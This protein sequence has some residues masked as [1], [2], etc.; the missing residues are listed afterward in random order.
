MQLRRIALGGFLLPLLGLLAWHPA[1]GEETDPAAPGAVPQPVPTFAGERQI[2]VDFLFNYYDQD[3]DRSPVTGGIGTEDLQV[4]AP[5]IVVNWAVS[6]D[7]ILSADLGMDTVSSASMARIDDSVSGASKQDRRVFSK[8]AASHRFG[9]QTFTFGGGFSKEYDYTSFHGT[10]AWS[11]EL[12][13]RNT[14]LSFGARHFSDTVDLIDIDGRHRGQD[15]RTTTDLVF[16]LTQVLGE[17]TVGWLELNYSDQSGFLSTSF[18]EVILAPA[19]GFPQGEHVAERLPDSRARQAAGVGINHGFTPRI[20]QRFFYRYYDDDW[21]I[22][23]HTVEAETH[24]RLPTE[25]EIWLYP[26]LRW[27]TQTAADHYGPPR[28]FTGSEDYFTTDPDLSEFDST[29]LGF[30]AR[31]FLRRAPAGLLRHLRRLDFRATSYD[32]D[33]GLQA[34]SI[35]FG[36]GWS[37]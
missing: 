35:S 13:Q 32:R 24:F 37:F 22:G 27:H 6:D 23:A 30:G 9:R 36:L 14:S 7:W 31:A 34:I 11:I 26:I 4:F 17:S 3:G 8:L 15:D 25:T 5:V 10:A 16:S 33:D 29:K 2:D 12:N 21:G 20:V 18:Y 1:R 28:T 19:P